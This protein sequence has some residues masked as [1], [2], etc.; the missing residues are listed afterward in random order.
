MNSLKWEGSK[1]LFGNTIFTADSSLRIWSQD[2][3]AYNKSYSAQYCFAPEVRNDKVVW[4]DDSSLELSASNEL[5]QISEFQSVEEA[6]ARYEE[7]E[8]IIISK[9][10][11]LK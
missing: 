7:V 6:K 11:N 5:D 8:R 9:K 4:V 2:K 10:E 3:N 1:D